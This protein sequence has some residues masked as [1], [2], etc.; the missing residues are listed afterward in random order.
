MVIREPK[1]T[2]TSEVNLPFLPALR[3]RSQYV[4]DSDE[5]DDTEFEDETGPD[6]SNLVRM[7]YQLPVNNKDLGKFIRIQG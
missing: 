6:T 7:L 5:E 2:L 1:K 3:G 4:D